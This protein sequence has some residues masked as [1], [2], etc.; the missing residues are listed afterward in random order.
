M[1]EWQK[2]HRIFGIRVGEKGKWLAC[3]ALARGQVS[4]S[5]L[6]H[7]KVA[8]HEETNTWTICKLAALFRTEATFHPCR[9]VLDRHNVPTL[10]VGSLAASASEHFG[11]PKIKVLSSKIFNISETMRLLM[12]S[13]VSNLW[14]L[15]QAED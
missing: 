11:D 2:P 15:V 10:L 13:P 4:P 6:A 9:K 5:L 1:L 14:Y 7:D 3:I 8:N 12:Q